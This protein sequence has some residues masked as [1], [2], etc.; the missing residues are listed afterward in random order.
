MLKNRFPVSVGVRNIDEITGDDRGLF[1]IFKVCDCN[2]MDCCIVV[3]I[4]T[5]DSED[6][7]IGRIV[8]EGIELDDI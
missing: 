5:A 1:L 2:C 8:W 7:S 3:V 4:I 6:S